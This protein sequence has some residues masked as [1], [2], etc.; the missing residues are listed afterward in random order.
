MV[1]SEGLELLLSKV[2]PTDSGEYHKRPLLVVVFGVLG[3]FDSIE[4]ATKLVSALPRI[5]SSGIELIGIGI[6]TTL[7]R[8]IFSAFTGFPLN[9]LIIEQDNSLHCML[10]LYRGVITPLGGW[11]NM[12]IMCSGIGSP[13]TLGEVLRGYTGDKKANQSYNRKIPKSTTTSWFLE[14][15]SIFICR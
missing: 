11:I 12:L 8:D 9:Q 7:S 5:R 6:G 10:D 1:S 3:D 14:V 15:Q 13:G 2:N 4:Y